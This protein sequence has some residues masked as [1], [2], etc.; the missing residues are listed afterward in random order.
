MNSQEVTRIFKKSSDIQKID[1]TGDSCYQRTSHSEYANQCSSP[2]SDHHH[3]F[4]CSFNVP[5]TI[6]R[7]SCDEDS[8]GASANYFQSLDPLNIG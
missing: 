1:L 8:F 5:E 6:A 4:E 2:S 7:T 3:Y